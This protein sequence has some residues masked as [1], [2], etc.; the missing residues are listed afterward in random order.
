MSLQV[1][2]GFKKFL[3]S[4]PGIRLYSFGNSVINLYAS[5][6]LNKFLALLPG[7]R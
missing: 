1:I 6:G 7:I 3:V 4:L 5:S 2:F